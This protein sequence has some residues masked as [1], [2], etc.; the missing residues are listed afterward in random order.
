VCKN[1][2]YQVLK[3]LQFKTCIGVLRLVYS[4][5]IFLW[6]FSSLP[7]KNSCSNILRVHILARYYFE[8]HIRKHLRGSTCI[9]FLMV[10]HKFSHN[11]C[12]VDVLAFI[13]TLTRFQNNGFFPYLESYLCCLL[14][15]VAPY[16]K[17]F[18]SYLSPCGICSSYLRLLKSKKKM[19]GYRAFFRDN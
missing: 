6:S 8:V 15:T 2:P 4:F 12:L 18:F 3:R 13:T 10:L 11:H 5:F 17:A 1:F 14:R 9:L 19:G 7:P 16:R